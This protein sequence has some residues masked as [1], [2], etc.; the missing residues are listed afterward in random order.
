MPVLSNRCKPFPSVSICRYSTNLRSVAAG[1]CPHKDNDKRCSYQSAGGSTARSNSVRWSGS[2]SSRIAS[3]MSVASVVRFTI[4]LTK[5]LS[6]PS[7][8]AISVRF[9]TL[10][11]ITKRPTKFQVGFFYTS[12]SS[13]DG[14]LSK[15]INY[16]IPTPQS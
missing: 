15:T 3:T 9:F 10:P 12:P 14:H 2:A 11:P 8:A 13:R 6:T 4:R 5:L 16:P 7:S 1:V